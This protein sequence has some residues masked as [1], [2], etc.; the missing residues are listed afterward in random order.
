MFSQ[1]LCMSVELCIKGLRGP[2]GLSV[3]RILGHRNMKVRASTDD[4]RLN[5]FEHF[6]WEL[7]IDRILGAL[8]VYLNILME[9][10]NTYIDCSIF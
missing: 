9:V 5:V 8:Q 1:S 7:L 10:F 2:S 4:A 3:L 6:G